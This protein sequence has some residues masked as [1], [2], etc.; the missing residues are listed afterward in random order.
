MPP[1]DYL[2]LT[3]RF[4][5]EFHIPTRDTYHPG[6][7]VDDF[8]TNGNRYDGPRQFKIDWIETLGFA[9]TSF[10]KIYDVQGFNSSAY[11]SATILMPK[12]FQDTGR[13]DPIIHECVHFLQHNTITEDKRYIKF[14]G[15]NFNEYF[16]QRVELEA[17]LIQ[18]AYICR[19]CTERA[20]ELLSIS[21]QTVVNAAL[22]KVLGGSNI[23]SAVPALFICKERSLI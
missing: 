10:N 14:T 16:S 19:E 7:N 8:Y 1:L 17:H 4:M 18:V 11:D 15:T 9:E 12:R 21:E 6:F 3:S 2:L 23:A 13:H 5:A 20:S 22:N